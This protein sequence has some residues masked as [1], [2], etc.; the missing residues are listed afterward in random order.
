[1][2]QENVDRPVGQWR[3][4]S[5]VLVAGRG[6]TTVLLAFDKERFY[7]LAGTAAL[8]WRMLADGDSAPNIAKR[9]AAQ[10][11]MMANVDDVEADV[12]R[13]LDDFE[14]RG[15][16][17]RAGLSDP[18]PVSQRVANT[19]RPARKARS[20]K[21][22]TMACVIRLLLVTGALRIL[23]LR[24]TL[25]LT[26]WLTEAVGPSLAHNS[27]AHD[28]AEQVELARV[29]TPLKPQ[30]LEKSVVLLWFLRECGLE[31]HLRIGVLAQP[32][33]AHA[34]VECNGAII[35]EDPEQLT[36]YCV[37]PPI[38]SELLQTCLR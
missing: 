38:D 11:N 36:R 9:L 33:A 25:R 19:H 32:F 27:M 7:S 2:P 1:M 5:S 26:F 8:V 20:T 21:P 17:G 22:S 34:W 15:L 12:N 14:T 10:H 31:A 28:I 13:L 3:Q 35:A 18:R 24:R 16:G 4:R 30:C 29:L 37:F 6:D 23:G